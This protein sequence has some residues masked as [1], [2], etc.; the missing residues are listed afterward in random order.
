MKNTKAPGDPPAASE[1][2]LAFT[3]HAPRDVPLEADALHLAGEIASLLDGHDRARREQDRQHQAE[4]D[5]SRRDVAR[6]VQ[7]VFQLDRVLSACEA[8]LGEA[9]LSR[10]HKQI[11]V[12]KD[13]FVDHLAAMGYRWYDP[14]GEEFV[15]DLVEAVEVDDHRCSSE[16]ERETIVETREP[17]VLFDGAVALNG[18]V[19]VGVPEP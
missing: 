8:R 3:A 5:R 19:V 17:I 6:Q 2:P 10:I 7:L 13:Q 4:R 1:N 9:G 16:Y 18:A 14:V 15:G 12:L 11:R